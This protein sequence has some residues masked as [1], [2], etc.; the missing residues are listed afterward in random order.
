MTALRTATCVAAALAIGLGGCNQSQQGAGSQAQPLLE[1]ARQ[2]HPPVP[3]VPIPVG[4]K[5]DMARN[6]LLHTGVG[7]FVDHLYKGRADRY[8]VVRFFKREMPVSRWTEVTYM[9]TRGEHTL[10]FEKGTERCR[11]VV[12]KGSWFHRTYV[13]VRVWTVGR[14][15]PPGKKGAKGTARR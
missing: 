8:A 4:F 11:V 10:E 5:E 13:D 15:E 7:R 3:D 2:R 6:R 12:R 14:I 9:Q 1:L